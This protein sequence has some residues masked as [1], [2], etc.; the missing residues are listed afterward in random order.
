LLYKTGSWI[1]YTGLSE[2]RISIE[3]DL[4]MSLRLADTFAYTA[5]I[6]PPSGF[7]VVESSLSG[8]EVNG[9][10]GTLKVEVPQYTFEPPPFTITMRNRKLSR[11]DHILDSGIAALLGVGVGGIISSYVALI[12]LRRSHGH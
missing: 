5:S 9:E 2:R 6:I 7:E 3:A 12:L 11:L 4:K 8:G 1:E 10:P